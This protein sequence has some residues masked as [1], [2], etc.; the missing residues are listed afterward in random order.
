M[1][2]LSSKITLTIALVLGAIGGAV[3]V[4]P[5]PGP[6]AIGAPIDTFV[7]ILIIASAI[8]GSKYLIGK[9]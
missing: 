6:P 8:L 1:K 3:A 2:A 5:P 9:K 4:P 7:V